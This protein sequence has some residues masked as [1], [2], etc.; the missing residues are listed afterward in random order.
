MKRALGASRTGEAL[1]RPG[2]RLLF[3]EDPVSL[4]EAVL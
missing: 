3:N 4:K 2:Y 1:D